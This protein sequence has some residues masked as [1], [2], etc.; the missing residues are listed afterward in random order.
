MAL[1]AMPPTPVMGRESSG[2]PTLNQFQVSPPSV[3]R[4]SFDCKELPSL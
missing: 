3:E 2:R 1:N 4:L